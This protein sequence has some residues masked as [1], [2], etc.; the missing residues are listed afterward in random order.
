MRI[1][2]EMGM[3]A[4]MWNITGYD[5]NAKSADD[6]ENMVSRRV[7]GGNVILLHYGCQLDMGADRSRT[8]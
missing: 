6:I 2:R 4:V 3:K 7:R 1:I 5:W 8:V